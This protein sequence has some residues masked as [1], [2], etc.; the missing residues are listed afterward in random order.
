MI[1]QVL[2]KYG[3]KNCQIVTTW[4]ALK[5]RKNLKKSS[6]CSYINVIVHSCVYEKAEQVRNK[7]QKVIHV[8]KNKFNFM[9]LPV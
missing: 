2:K 5:M 9:D 8:S 7:K 6:F 4:D 3:C 1:L